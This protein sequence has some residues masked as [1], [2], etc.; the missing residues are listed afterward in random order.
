M[1]DITNEERLTILSAARQ[2]GFDYHEDGS[3]KLVCTVDQLVAFSAAVATAT[4]EQ[5][6]GVK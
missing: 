4:I 6:V 2:L 5:I 1:N 3:G